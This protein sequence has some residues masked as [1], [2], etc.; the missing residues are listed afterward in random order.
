MLINIV[1]LIGV[2]TYRFIITNSARFPIKFV[3]C[4]MNITK[5]PKSTRLKV[6]VVR[7]PT[8]YAIIIRNRV[9]RCIKI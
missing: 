7:I 1:Y 4:H 9:D 5:Q 6:K 8:Q 2:I 3:N